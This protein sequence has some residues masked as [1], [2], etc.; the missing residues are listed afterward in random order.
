MF[1]QINNLVRLKENLYLTDFLDILIIAL[2]IYTLFL[3]LRNTRTLMAF[4]GLAFAVGLYFIA[5]SFNLYVT[6]M[7]LKYFVGVAVLIF[8]IIFQSEIRKY[9][10]FLGLIGSRQ[11]KVLPL[12]SRSPSTSEIIQ[13]CVR[14][15]QAKIGA[16]IVIQ[17]KVGLDQFT[18]GG[19]MLDGAISEELLSSIFEPHSYGHDGAVLINNNKVAKFA[20]HLPLS[21]NFKEIGKHGTRHSAAVGIT[22]V[23]DAFTIVVSEENGKIS[24]TRDGKLKTLQEFTDLEKELEKYIRSKFSK[25]T[26]ENRLAKIIR[27]DFMIRLS[28]LLIAG[29]IWF[30]AAFQTGIVEKTYKIPLNASKTSGSL[31]IQ[32]YSPKEVKVKISARGEDAFREVSIN[33]F[34]IDL[35][36]TTLQNGVNKLTVSKEIITIPS[37]FSIVSFEPN[38]ILL[39]AQKYYLAE[40]PVSI[41]TVG[42]L[43]N[44]LVLK[45]I[46]AEP[47]KLKLW[48]PE[49]IEAPKEITTEPL[50]I[51]DKTESTVAPVKLV[52][53]EGL[54]LEDDTTEISVALVI[55]QPSRR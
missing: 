31:L 48:V 8:V 12:T 46:E 24:V 49:G 35:D 32:E 3:F 52:I 5:K 28:A 23:T 1:N 21:T 30:F 16:L 54:R 39:T 47:N 4:L 13:A 36:Y 7:A 14:M 34:K 2:L 6:L 53:P 51:S 37:N 10:E 20:V 11:I 41:K 19:I 50:D 15:A 38:I 22:E 18:D 9:F 33:D 27:Q 17:G 25:S 40:I 43:K 29:I 45:S 26:K 55:E 44:K 42:V